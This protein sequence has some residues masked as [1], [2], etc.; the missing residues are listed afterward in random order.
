MKLVHVLAVAFLWIAFPALAVEIVKDVSYSDPAI[1]RQVLDIYAPSDA[2]NLPVVIWIHGGGWQT[3]DKSEVE[4]KPRA[5]FSRGFVFVSTNYRLLP[6][7]D[8]ETIIRDVAKSI[9]WVHSIRSELSM[10]S[11]YVNDWGMMYYSQQ[12]GLELFS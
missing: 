7:V 4:H 10:N 5:F 1:E 6:A 3:G 12:S 8:M 9:H 11:R 2:K